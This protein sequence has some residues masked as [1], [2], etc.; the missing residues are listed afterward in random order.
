[1]YLRVLTIN[2]RKQGISLLS[3]PF[4]HNAQPIQLCVIEKVVKRIKA[5]RLMHKNIEAVNS[6]ANP[7]E[8]KIEDLGEIESIVLEPL[9]IYVLEV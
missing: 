6:F 8:L 3:L 9:S 5:K 1:M 2:K 4:T 7:S